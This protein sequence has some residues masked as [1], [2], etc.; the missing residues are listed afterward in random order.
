MQGKGEEVG[1]EWCREGEEGGGKRGRRE[2]NDDTEKVRLARKRLGGVLGRDEH[3]WGDVVYERERREQV[4]VSLERGVQR[5]MQRLVVG[6]GPHL[7][8][9]E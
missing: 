1:G 5:S 8:S 7:R 3:L 2:G 6:C 9:S 4:V